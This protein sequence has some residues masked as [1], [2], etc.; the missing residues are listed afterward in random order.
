MVGYI[1]K[2]FFYGRE[3]VSDV[4]ATLSPAS[5]TAATITPRPCGPS[6]RMRRHADLSKAI[7]P[8]GAA[9]DISPPGA[10]AS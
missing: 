3:F 9:R 1:C 5:W 8:P 10:A 2:S 6:Y 4:G 7:H